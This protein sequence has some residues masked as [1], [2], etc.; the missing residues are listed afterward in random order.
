[1]HIP[2]MQQEWQRRQSQRS[3]W[4]L[5]GLLAI[6]AGTNQMPVTAPLF[7]PTVQMVSGE[8]VAAA[9]SPQ[10]ATR[11]RSGSSARYWQHLAPRDNTAI[12]LRLELHATSRPAASSRALYLRRFLRPPTGL[13][14]A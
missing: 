14:F 2:V 7:H 5:L 12:R 11:V 9:E 8:T 10:P 3:V 6:V 4:A 1:M 13:P